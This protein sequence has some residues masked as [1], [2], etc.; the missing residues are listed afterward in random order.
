MKISE[1]GEFGLIARIQKMLPQDVPGVIVGIG[2]DVA[3]LRGNGDNVWL[4]TCD[5]QMEGAHFLRTAVSPRDLGHKAL[6]INLSDIAAKGGTPR[7][8]LVSLGLPK[9]LPVAF[10][11]E[12]YAGLRAAA[13]ASG[14]GIIGGNISGSQLGFFIDLFLIGEA[15]EK[16]VLLRSGARPGDR[17]LVTGSLGDAAAGAALCLD[18]NLAGPKG[19]C[20]A[21][22]QRFNRPTPRLQEGR[23]IAHSHLATAM[24]DISDGLAGDLGHLCE[25]SAVGARVHADRLPV[26][27]ANRKLSQEAQG[28]EWH[29][30]ICGGEDYELL[31]TASPERASG[32]AEEIT[33]AT[34]TPVAVIGEILSA[35]E[36]RQFVLPDGRTVPLEPKAWDH[37][38]QGAQEKP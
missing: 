10:I 21:A 38:K 24:L 14:T 30:S 17:I 9:D 12:L 1:L 8:A 25:R 36:G 29:F 15:P 20:R 28:D 4:V 6:A 3:V 2:D 33:A 19:Y 27:A 37:L 31:F 26:H 32:L 7:F 5:V 34:G 35:G 23:L 11:D 22:A 13:E 18:P 16:D